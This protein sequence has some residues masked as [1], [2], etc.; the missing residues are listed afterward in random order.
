MGK[1]LTGLDEPM[2]VICSIFPET[3]D[4]GEVVEIIGCV[5]DIR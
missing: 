4:T 5:T 2:W 1:G 3:T